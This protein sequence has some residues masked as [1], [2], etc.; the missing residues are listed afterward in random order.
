MAEN[1]ETE[2]PAQAH[3]WGERRAIRV[4]PDDG[5]FTYKGKVY[6]MNIHPIALIMQIMLAVIVVLALAGIMDAYT[7]ITFVVV[8][9]IPGFILGLVRGIT[10]E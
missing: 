7:A 4:A 9:C 10:R 5:Q 8:I 3:N 2:T 6:E 1:I